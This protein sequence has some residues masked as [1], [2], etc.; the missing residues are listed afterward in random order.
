MIYHKDQF[1]KPKE[2]YFN[3]EDNRKKLKLMISKFDR[4]KVSDK[5]KILEKIGSGRF[6]EVFRCV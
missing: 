6:S 2:F 3:S 4:S 5:Y 1:Y